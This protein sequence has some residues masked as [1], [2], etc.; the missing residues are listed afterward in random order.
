MALLGAD[1]TWPDWFE[2]LYRD[3]ELS[4]ANDFFWEPGTSV[5]HSRD[6][7]LFTTLYAWF[8]DASRVYPGVQFVV[9]LGLGIHRDHRL[10]FQAA[11]VLSKS[12]FPKYLEQRIAASEAYQW[13]IPTYF[14][15]ASSFRESIRAYPL[16]AGKQ[17]HPIERYWRMSR[18]CHTHIWSRILRMPEICWL[19]SAPFLKGTILGSGGVRERKEQSDA[20]TY[21]SKSSAR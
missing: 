17:R 1:Y 18:S 11:L 9:P 10:V 12:I 14:Y 3:P 5:V 20:Q 16:K 4:D 19:P 13:Q 2:I 8:A 7:A 21:Q 6:A 15:M